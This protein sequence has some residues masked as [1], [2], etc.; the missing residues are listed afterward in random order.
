MLFSAD[1]HAGYI[2]HR[3]EIDSAMRNVM[4]NGR[5]IFGPKVRDFEA[6]FAKYLG[7]EHCIGVANGTDAVHLSLRACGVKTGDGVITASHTAVAT[8]AAVEWLGAIPVLVDIDPKSYTLDPQKV[9]NMLQQR[10]TALTIKAIIPVHLYGH[11]SD[12]NALQDI[13]DRYGVVL[14][15]DCAQAHGAA[16]G[17]RKAGSMGACGAF[18]FYPTKNLGAFGDGGAIVT[19]DAGIAERLSSLQQ[20]GWRERYISEGTGYNSRL[21]ELQAAVLDVKLQWLDAGNDR[22]RRISAL[23]NDGLSGMPLDLPREKPGVRHVYHQ[24]VIQSE[25]RDLLRIYLESNG[26]QASILYPMAVHQQP[27]YRNRVI[28]GEGGMAV[29]ESIVQKILGL[30]IYP[31]L[32][33]EEVEKVIENIR[34]YFKK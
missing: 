12:M 6:H 3:S 28:V 19:D 17:H 29:T 20:Y 24:Y 9:E 23:Y 7:V 16:V 4:E 11:P 21:D 26:I 30:P 25:E 33:D 15:E 2:A 34:S 10:K 5:Y 31:E 1:P 22:R 18:S 13:A 32:G 14:I 27:A 8:V